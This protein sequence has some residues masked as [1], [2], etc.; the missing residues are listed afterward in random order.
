MYTSCLIDVFKHNFDVKLSNILDFFAPLEIQEV[1]G[2][3]KKAKLKN[4]IKINKNLI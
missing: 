1:I 2:A 4:E 3:N